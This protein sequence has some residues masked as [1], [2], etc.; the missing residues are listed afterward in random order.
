MQTKT[1]LGEVSGWDG[2]SY[3]IQDKL[4]LRLIDL[5]YLRITL[6]RNVGFTYQSSRHNV[7]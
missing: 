7:A 5:E 2:S 4:A 3:I 6:L 1:G